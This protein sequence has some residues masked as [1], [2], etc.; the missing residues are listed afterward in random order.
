[1][2][3]A[4]I[5]GGRVVN[6][7]M[8]DPAAVDEIQ[9]H[10]AVVQTD[11]AGPGW[12]W[13]AEGGFVA[14]EPEPMPEPEPDYGPALALVDFLRRFTVAERVTIREARKTDPIIDDF[15]GLMESA[16]TIR[17]RHPDTLAGLGYLVQQGK[18]TDER[19]DEITGGKPL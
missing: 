16:G 18:L 4:L 11:T 15:M 14:P 8:C 19:A 12:A 5:N 3:Y 9:G 13:T 2:R 6:V 7:I 10:D 1:M 17:L